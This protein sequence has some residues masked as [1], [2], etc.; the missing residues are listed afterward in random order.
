[1]DDEREEGEIV[2]L[3]DDDF[4]EN[5]ISSD[6]EVVIEEDEDD[7][8]KRILELEAKNSELEKIA[9]ISKIYDYGLGCGSSNFIDLV[10]DDDGGDDDESYFRQPSKYE[11]SSYTSSR[12]KSSH[13]KRRKANRHECKKSKRYKPYKSDRRKKPSQPN[14]SRVNSDSSSDDEFQYT[15]NERNKLQAAL[16]R[17]ISS[18]NSTTLKRKLIGVSQTVEDFIKEKEDVG[19]EDISTSM[20]IMKLLNKINIEEIAPKKKATVL[21]EDTE[22][23]LTEQELR[24]IALKSA[25]LKKAEAR[26]KRKIIETQPYSPTDDVDVEKAIVNSKPKD[27]L[28]NME[29][30]P[31]VSPTNQDGC[32]QPIDMELESDDESQILLNT[33]QEV[34]PTLAARTTDVTVKDVPQS[35][36]LPVPDE[37][38][39]INAKVPEDADRIKLSFDSVE[40][41]KLQEEDEDDEEALRASLLATLT[42]K[43]K[44][45]SNTST[46]KTSIEENPLPSEK[47]TSDTSVETE[48]LRKQAISSIGKRKHL[49]PN[50]F[51]QKFSVQVPMPMEMS[52]PKPMEMSM[53]QI[54]SNL[55]TALKRILSEKDKQ[56]VEGD[57]KVDVC[58]IHQPQK[59]ISETAKEIPAGEIKFKTTQAEI[60]ELKNIAQ[61]LNGGIFTLKSMS[62]EPTPIVKK[63][64]EPSTKDGDM[65]NN[66]TTSEPTV[67]VK[68][69]GEPI[70]KAND[71]PKKVTS[72]EPPGTAKKS[73]E[74]TAKINDVLKN[75]TSNNAAVETKTKDLAAVPLVISNKIETT[76]LDKTDTAIRSL[77]AVAQKKVIAE[78]HLSLNQKENQQ[79]RKVAVA[80]K[81]A[82][83]EK[84]P[85]AKK[86]KV[87]NNVHNVKVSRVITTPV[88]KPVKKLIIQLNNSDTDSDDFGLG[89]ENVETTL[90]CKSY[91]GVASPASYTYSPASPANLADNKSSDTVPPKDDHFQRKLDEYLKSARTRVEQTKQETKPI[92]KS[93]SLVS[94]LPPSSQL[95]YRKLISRMALLEKQKQLKLTKSKIAASK[96]K[97]SSNI[98][99][100][101]ANDLFNH[102]P[103]SVVPIEP[104]APL[105]GNDISSLKD[106][107]REDVVSLRSVD[108]PIPV[109]S[110]NVTRTPTTTVV[111]G[112]KCNNSNVPVMDV[113]QPKSVPTEAKETDKSLLMQN[114]SALSAHDKQEILQK[115][116]A[117]YMS[118]SDLYLVDLNNMSQL[119]NQ[120]RQEKEKQFQIESEIE[121]LEARV[122]ELKNQLVKQKVS[123]SKLYPVISSSHKNIMKKR[124]Q[125]MQLHKKCCY[126][127]NK[128]VGA[129][130]KIPGDPKADIAQKVRSLSSETKLLRNMRKPVVNGLKAPISTDGKF[131]ETELVCE[132]TPVTTAAST[133]P[134]KRPDDVPPSINGTCDNIPAPNSMANYKSPLDH[135]GNIGI[136]NP[137]SI[138]CPFQLLGQ[139]EDKE[140]TY[141][142][143]S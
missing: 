141:Q 134:S 115:S 110:S 93:P 95:E 39:L 21:E 41:R 79:L 65:L 57:A 92:K 63:T 124:S 42:A 70:A 29:I 140:C 49:L 118:Y 96:P 100:T 13:N 133:I 127:G 73:L 122:H 126:V 74:P 137:D 9:S 85:V 19:D 45:T 6:D 33:Q 112:T 55:K 32:L 27:E 121:E 132:D 12:R 28:D 114:F 78:P 68:K 20:E 97:P 10:D 143:L 64:C 26:K 50:P 61:K 24:L 40:Q 105:N 3:N 35:I 87:V 48:R 69:T 103:K 108:P 84:P 106:K 38:S 8:R 109:E 59:L 22:A 142:H 98:S 25:I 139:C 129:D 11:Y 94:H 37:I 53:P 111:S 125:S 138:V 99:I 47:T 91:S 104:I 67:I 117:E 58:R 82:S 102:K 7:L 4:Y 66:G 36:I 23:G 131:L 54:T 136:T 34:L 88:E 71:A 90:N 101:I 31:P 30:S 80:S 16:K 51:A 75:V 86:P 44:T 123:V 56:N 107:Q 60:I 15:T 2:D 5:I 52:M 14:R 89:Q 135:M 81:R 43:K 130:Y 128:I 77:K 119:V 76:S 120:A 83:D 1:M 72:S 46:K 17:N 116:E 62:N 113:E 18:T